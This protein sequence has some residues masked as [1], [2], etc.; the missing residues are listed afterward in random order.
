MSPNSP[1]KIWDDATASME[2]L[3]PVAFQQCAPKRYATPHGYLN[4]RLYATSVLGCLMSVRQDMSKLGTQKLTDMICGAG[5]LISRKL[6]GHQ[7][8]TYFVQEEFARAVAATELPVPFRFDQIHWPMPAMLFCLP[9]E[10]S[11]QLFGY[12]VPFIA[13]SQAEAGPHF[14]PTDNEIVTRNNPSITLEE[15]RFLVHFPVL[16]RN[17]LPSDYAG[18]WPLDGNLSDYL[19]LH[20]FVDYTPDSVKEMIL[21]SK[22]EKILTPEEDAEI[23]ARVNSFAIQLLMAITARPSFVETGGL[24]R[25]QKIKHGKI[26]KDALWHPNMVGQHY[27][28]KRS[29]RATQET[30]GH[31]KRMHWR[32]G[33]YRNQ[34]YGAHDIPVDQR[35]HKIIWI[36]PVLCGAG[37]E[38]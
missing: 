34:I 15:S 16:V 27:R 26:E 29:E 37:E 28:T 8:P 6:I 13:M 25:P 11:R 22:P 5:F 36:E 10:L 33:H 24:A 32:R 7:V 2:S 3:T 9:V 31:S 17:D 20:T 30:V 18:A 38:E 12:Y 4:P 1:F 35:P 14:S 21:E 19:G 23:S